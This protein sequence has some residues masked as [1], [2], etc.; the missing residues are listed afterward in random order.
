M[1]FRL[2]CF[3]TAFGALLAA[4]GC[5]GG[6][7][8]STSPSVPQ[9]LSGNVIDGYIAGA[10]VCLDVNSNLKCDADEPFGE[11]K[12]PNG[13]YSIDL[14][15]Y[16]GSIDGLKVV[17]EVPKGAI[18]SELGKI[19]KPF[20]LM[21][22]AENSKTVTPV[23]TMVVSDMTVRKV[24]AAEAEKAIVAK[25]NLPAENGKLLDV[26]VTKQAELLKVSQVVTAAVASAKENLVA[27]NDSKN[28]GLTNAQIVNA[29]IQDVKANV[30]TQ[31]L[32]S[33]GKVT[34]AVAAEISKAK[35]AGSNSAQ[36]VLV[37]AITKEAKIDSRLE[38]NVQQIVAQ[39]KAG[40]GAAFEMRKAFL[41]GFFVVSKDSGDYLDDSGTRIGRNNGFND[42]LTAEFIQLVETRP[43]ASPT[44][45]VWLNGVNG[46]KWYTKY[47]TSNVKWIY[48]GSKWFS[49]VGDDLSRQ[50]IFKENCVVL[51]AADGVTF[52]TKACAVAKDLA[53]KPIAD[54]L[55][56]SSGKSLIC[57][58]MDGV[59]PVP[60]CDPKAVFPTGSGVS[61]L[62]F[63]PTTDLIE[64]WT[65]DDPKWYGYNYEGQ[66]WK[67]PSAT[68]PTIA[69]FLSA[70]QSSPQWTGSN[71]GIGFKVKSIDST[72]TSGVV[73]FGENTSK[74]GCTGA[75]VSSF[76]ETEKFTVTR[77]GDRD[78]LRI[79]TPNLYRKRY[80]GDFKLESVFAVV[81][82]T[83]EVT[84]AGSSTPVS[85]TIQGIFSGEISKADR[86]ITMIFTGNI[87][88]GFQMMS[89]VAFDAT[90][91]VRG[92]D[93]FK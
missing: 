60:N 53:G 11:S 78:V 45:K 81:D 23:S 7:G 19:E 10:K 26:D 80:P 37:A 54:F 47:D 8:G 5:G 89:K 32:G 52:G 92:V 16:R 39:S 3:V 65:G 30:L 38:G 59:T 36:S 82:K 91:K 76:T 27:L 93:V 62:T 2:T 22:P 63:A 61:D 75:T 84:V 24:T 79:P 86:P 42:A 70:L 21:A 43:N 57:T 20:D 50:P 35:E 4:A 40:D 9:T 18:D 29:A 49:A 71:C 46:Q 17:A 51:P 44:R 77:V 55:K 83:V 12:D 72:G 34:P 28:L 6:G 90:A 74:A 31:V 67:D 85:K 64:I 1:S 48:D 25:F 73:E 56:D 88:A 68:T 13:S 15:K 41:E 69:K 66:N 14:S 33:D 58:M 87:D